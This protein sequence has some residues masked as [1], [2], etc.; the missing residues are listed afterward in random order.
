MYL[1]PDDNYW[2]ADIEA[3]SLT[4][5]TI[6]CMC[7]DN[8]VTGEQIDLVGKDDIMEWTAAN[9]E[10]IFVGHNFLKFDAPVL[11]KLAGARLS[12]RRV[13]DT[14]IFSQLYN[15]I[16]DG[17]GLEDWGERFGIPKVF[18]EDWDRYS[19]EMLHRCR[20]DVRITKHLYL[21]MIKVFRKIG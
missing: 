6:W 15:P 19:P 11:Y 5:D 3:N 8:I 10:A 18:H 16:L 21:K 12:V 1:T 20:Q 13:V 7:L 4:P 14:L 9:P 2:A 17:H